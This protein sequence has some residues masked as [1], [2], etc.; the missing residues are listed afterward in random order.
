MKTESLFDCKHFKQWAPLAISERLHRGTTILE[1]PSDHLR[2]PV[3][4]GQRG[5]YFFVWTNEQRASVQAASAQAQ[6]T[7][8]GMLLTSFAAWLMRY[9][10]QEEAV[11]GAV[12]P[13]DGQP[14]LYWLDL[15][16]EEAVTGT[17]LCGRL[18][19]RMADAHLLEKECESSDGLALFAYRPADAKWDVTLPAACD[20]GLIV[21]ETDGGWD[22][23]LEFNADLYEP[24]TVARMAGHWQGLLLGLAEEPERKT[25]DLPLLSEAE[26]HQ[27][28]VEWN[29][30]MVDDGCTLALHELFE[31]QA[32]QTPE[33]V[34]V[35]YEGES[36]TYRELDRRANQ[37]ARTLQKL[38]VQKETRVGICMER[39]LEMVIGLYAILKAGG[40]YVP[41]DPTYPA[42]RIAYLLQDAAPQVLLTQ[43]H[44]V[45]GL[46]AHDGS[47]FCVEQGDWLEESDEPLGTATGPDDLAYMIYTSGSTGNPKG[48]MIP[49]KGIVNRILWM[50]AEYQ[51]TA[52]D[53]V[54]QKTPFSFDV[55]VWEFFWPLM[56]GATLV[57]A[58][59]GGHQ[60]PAYLAELIRNA[61]ITTLHF[62]PSMLQVFL[63][64][65]SVPACTS[66]RQVMCSGEALPYSL[67]EQFFD[68][69]A[70]AA[71][72]N[73]YGPTEASVDV[74]YW[75][76]E[77]GYAKKIV[78]IGRPIANIQMYVLDPAMNPVPVGVAGEL[79]IGGI[80]LMRGYHNR[81]E[82]T[83][84]KLIANP[85]ASD[86]QDK[87]YRT[88][89]LA[90]FLP[91]GAIE[92]LGRIDHQV[93]IRGF[94]IEL[95][96]IEAALTEHDDIRE[97]V[98]TAWEALPGD[99][100]L[101]AYVVS[102]VETAAPSANVLKRFLEER[103]P[104]FMVPSLFVPMDALPLTP[105]GKVDRKALPLPDPRTAVESEY[106]APRDETELK[107]AAIWQ[108]VLGA[109]RVG[110][111][112]SFFELGGHSL[113]AMQVVSRVRQ[114][115]GASLSVLDLFQKA[116]VAQLAA[117][118]A[119]F[120]GQTA[121]SDMIPK[122]DRDGDM[123]PASSAQAQMYFLDQLEGGNPAYHI[124]TAMRLTGSLDAGALEASLQAV[125]R[126][127]ES[128]RTTFSLAD[129]RLMQVV[130][131]EMPWSL[132]VTDLRDWPQGKRLEQAER[133]AT[134]SA[135]ASFDLDNGPL[136]RAEL[137][138]LGNED[139]VLAIALHHIISD[140]WSLSV[141]VKEVSAV[142]EAELGGHVPGLPELSVQY[143]DVSEW[144]R[145]RLQGERLET[146]TS[147]WK[148][149][150]AGAPALLELPTD[151]IRPQVMS[152]HGGTVRFAIPDGLYARLRDVCQ[153]AQATPY[154]LLLAAFQILLHRYAGQDDITVGSPIAGRQSA[155][156]EPLIGYFVNTLVMRSTWQEDEQLSF[157]DMLARVRETSLR[158]YA[159]QDLPFERLVEALAP[160]RNLSYNPLFQV[161][162]VLQNTPAA[163]WSFAGVS[164]EELVMH[165][166][167]TKFDLS[168]IVE[169][170][171]HGGLNAQFEYNA[172]LF[173]K[174]TI[175]RMAGHFLH[176]LDGI[177]ANPAADVRG[178]PWLDAEERRQLLHE[179][180]DTAVP[181]ER[182]VTLQELFERQVA[183]TPD[184]TA[185]V[186][187]NVS[188][189]YRELNDRANRLAHY[190]QRFGVQPDQMVGVC[191]ER[192]VDMVVSLLAIVK[193]GGAYVP[194]DPAYPAERIKYL[195]GDA[196]LSI[197][198]TQEHLQGSLPLDG[199]EQETTLIAVDRGEWLTE[200]A[201]NVG[202]AVT[203]QHLAYMIYTSGSTGNPKGAMVPH[204]GIVN[205]LLWMQDA[206]RLTSADRVL[207]KT[208][209]SF[210][211]SVWE[212]FWPL[213]TGAT[214]VV[215]QPGGHQDPAYLA[216][217]IRSA[218]VTTLHFV[219]SMLQVFLEEPSVSSCTSIRQV[220]CSGE[221]LPFSL[222][223]RFFERF[224]T[225]EL[226]NLYGP[227]EAS[228]DVTYWACERKSDRTIVPIGLPIAN[229][230]LY[231]LDER[232]NPVPIGVAGE[233]M[234]GGIGLARGYHNRPELT[235]EKF[236]PNP[237][238]GTP[239]D[240]LY[241]TGDLARYLPDGTIEYLGRLDHQVKI[242][243][244]R[245]ELGEI[246]TAL[247][248]HDALRE[249]VVMAREDQPG[250][251]RLA[252]YFTARD[253]AEPPSTQ[254]LQRF[255]KD[256]LPD[257]MTPSFFVPLEKMPLTP[258]GKV[259]RKALPKPEIKRDRS[260]SAYVA[261][262]TKEE[263]I[264]AGI[265][266]QVLR[267]DQVGVQDN[268]FSLGGDSILSMQI[269]AKANQAG[270]RLKPKDLFQN[271]TVAQLVRAA[272]PTK[273]VVEEKDEVAGDA[274]LTPIQH[275]FF[276][277]KQPEPH[278]WNLPLMV[279]CRERP[280]ES[281]L[282]RAVEAVV[283]A[284]DAFRLRY[285]Q[286]NGTWKQFHATPSTEG[287]SVRVDLS[288]FPVAE[289]RAQIEAHAEEMQSRLDLAA[290][291]LVQVIWYDCGIA[292]PSR[293]FLLLHHLISDGV[294]WRIL[295]DDLELAYEQSRRGET[296]QL[297]EKST[298]YQRWAKR[299]HEH[300]QSPA[301]QKELA[302]WTHESRMEVTPLPFDSANDGVNNVS[303][304]GDAATLTVTISEAQTKALL[305]QV[306][307]TYRTQIN[308][309]LLAALLQA[310]TRWK[311]DD[312]LL[313]DLEGHG[314]E[315]L[316][317][318]V[319]LTR[320]V[321]WFTSIYPVLLG[322]EGE[323]EPGE[324][325]KRVKEQLRSVPQ[326]GIGYG[327]LRHLGDEDVRAQLAAVPKAQILFN[328]LG[329]FDQIF[330]TSKIFQSSAETGGAM[331]SPNSTRT[332][333]LDI[334]CRVTGGALEMQFTYGEGVFNRERVAE[335]A[336]SFREALLV[337]IEH[338]LTA[339]AGLTPSDVP[340]ARL[341][342]REL[343]A[344]LTRLQNQSHLARTR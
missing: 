283:L 90:R 246:E 340:G 70:T 134:E 8:A 84:E 26:R 105:N 13:V 257:Y 265:W 299:L 324:V 194:I 296:I 73:L 46:P 203:E 325:L 216:E 35:V 217:L 179:W 22:V 300:A 167:T 303:M 262:R 36:L 54:L 259:D 222:Q 27:L 178:L 256:S 97:A 106:V 277:Q 129:D 87:L 61:R 210:D 118:L 241:R 335:L 25:A 15:D 150:L 120:D 326:R 294:T 193:A 138:V 175:E 208:P 254:E 318:D 49:H 309:V 114:Q 239:S 83:A 55:S 312:T 65:P 228:V 274:F 172:D 232:L 115:F 57:V 233:L 196:R 290:G 170:A 47:V 69:L 93:K 207:Q 263:E 182:G 155:E 195:I 183:Q 100:R 185:L 126:R 330:D 89:D 319:D 39:S 75:A 266:Q 248:Q 101:V 107:L 72:H 45:A 305:Q 62:V 181:Y 249:V 78:P 37:L 310:F 234:I 252:A 82:L 31:A 304:E 125:I 227:T 4:S 317:D 139:H 184:H 323:T 231:V 3:S 33:R 38:G 18:A 291:P 76:C 186:Y 242:R 284:H 333:L 152:H 68:T 29:D 98:V 14:R 235:A 50:Q 225:A 176:L 53:R 64:E 48:A 322:T 80:G 9:L 209:F 215:A 17:E 314:R 141:L 316:F 311:G 331:R 119:D 205:R 271:Q 289:H 180:N 229:I 94:R 190:L 292:A 270:L 113:T 332:H 96:E 253:G 12:L 255:L 30:T 214:L 142:Y 66:I 247:A 329:Q 230:Q 200:S 177:S 11:F 43:E 198:L 297:P 44:L 192:S 339:K 298:S 77:R 315:P 272:V 275:W 343:D 202:A 132:K 5:R 102:P 135:Q 20:L 226:H 220:M 28:L 156:T 342:Q 116:T 88:G 59:P 280:D 7:L 169:N 128:L 123:C 219:P 104:A 121:E 108:H 79:M 276:E 23:C 140:G 224:D 288:D 86:P 334:V 34:A 58:R 171:A 136:V 63:E 16:G 301:L 199:Q 159:H 240:R 344:F 6:T 320:T 174:A 92:Y 127:H 41:I 10:R 112:D 189:T 110:V 306:P 251:K 223:E 245:I 287:V 260:A 187:E 60:D 237:L 166:G 157:G 243:G 19:Q 201:K 160:E 147:H 71:L 161:L 337:L 52:E 24:E 295:L 158:A 221:A 327:L 85:F 213:L 130:Q 204:Q 197:L 338:C 336:D 153:G 313:L 188:L 261:P 99:K 206:Y 137:L 328:Y 145:E 74:T 32:A 212:F 122:R 273:T 268:F 244:F 164:A 191:M 302:Y 321:G 173:E 285:V 269:I 162:F 250:E 124:Y 148:E 144:Q 40:A 308:D 282:R 151:H 267:L 67:Q 281:A 293:L 56:A 133:L 131:A 143:A 341:S 286:E 165:N 146:L 264:M 51:L 2:P 154:M 163:D 168:L 258:N 218:G 278:H 103:L 236:I 42:E 95:G 117:W 111:L 109:D 91:D 211:V 279:E 238:T 1:L 149:E 81:P 21:S 307:R